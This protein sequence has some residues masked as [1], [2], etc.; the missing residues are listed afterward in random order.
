MD[1]AG[2]FKANLGVVTEVRSF[3]GFLFDGSILDDV[4]EIVDLLA[5]IGID[6]GFEEFC[7]GADS[8][9]EDMEQFVKG[10]PELVGVIGGQ[11]IVHRDSAQRRRLGR[12]EDEKFG[13][14]VL[15]ELFG[16]LAFEFSCVAGHER[17]EIGRKNR[18]GFDGWRENDLDI[19]LRWQ[20]TTNECTK[21][22]CSSR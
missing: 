6:L 2:E 21:S 8:R 16:L 5:I 17:I 11:L 20:M 18:S 22:L 15:E 13:V 10:E 7:D 19:G 3:N 9:L 14:N 12:H 4:D 1:P